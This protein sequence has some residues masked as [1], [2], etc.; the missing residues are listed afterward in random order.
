MENGGSRHQHD[1]GKL[2]VVEG[3]G[4]VGQISRSPTII[5][6]KVVKAG[7]SPALQGFKE[8]VPC[9][10]LVYTETNVINLDPK[11]FYKISGKTL[12]SNNIHEQVLLKT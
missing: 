2:I 9:R 6:I 3:R 7:T 1:V 4:L 12:N 5:N 11:A 8:N 10:M